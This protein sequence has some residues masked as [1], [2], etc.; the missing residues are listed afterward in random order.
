[1]WRKK[2]PVV[3]GEK[4]HFFSEAQ[5]MSTLL[6]VCQD[7]VATF[8]RTHDCPETLAAFEKECKRV[9]VANSAYNSVSRDLRT[10][11]EYAA[12]KAS[13]LTALEALPPDA[14]RPT[15]HFPTY[16][17]ER[18]LDY[19]HLGNILS[20]VPVTYPGVA[21]AC[22]ATTGADKRVVI[23]H[24]ATGDVVGMLEPSAPQ[25]TQ[26][27]GHHAAVL[28]FAQHTTNPRYAV[29]SG[30]DGM[31]VVWDLAHDTPIQTLRDHRRFAVRVAFSQD[32]RFLASASYDKTIHIYEDEQGRY[33]R[34]HTI[35]LTSNP[36]AL[37]FVRGAPDQAGERPWLVYTVRDSVMLH[38]VGMPTH[39]TAWDVLTY[40]TNPDPDDFHA[41]YSL[42]DLA[43]HPSGQYISAQTGDHGTP[44]ALSSGS[45]HTLSRLLLMPLFSDKRHST[46]WTE[47]PS[48]SFTSPRHAWRKEGDGAWIT[49][50]DGILRLVG[51]DG[52]VHARVPCHGQH[53]DDD[54][55]AASWRHGGNTVIK[56]VAVLYEKDTEHIITC[57]FDRTVRIVHPS[58]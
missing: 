35:T 47:S 19:L 58:T 33:V 51:L 6:G 28:C 34:R 20:V 39:T 1:M 45:D 40:N 7:I 10:L 56:G 9:P 36:E 27:H 43:M 30:M 55:S 24:L 54:L 14:T 18:T 49:G 25:D 16:K 52:R 5:V 15:A 37:L 57:G 38:Y 29:T 23:T 11:V 12:S 31:L 4:C 46:L 42:L 8:L 22:I 32:A 41:S 13:A 53:R 48:S 50:E 2:G 26:P 44:C 3:C 21:G 17:L